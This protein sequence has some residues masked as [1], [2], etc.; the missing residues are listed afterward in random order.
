M[1]RKKPSYIM[2]SEDETYD[3]V[4]ITV[5]AVEAAIDR[6]CSNSTI[7][8]PD[9]EP[10]RGKENDL[11][12][13]MGRSNFGSRMGATS[14]LRLAQGLLI[15]E[16]D[17]KGRLQREVGSIVGSRKKGVSKEFLAKIW[18]IR[19][20][21]AQGAIDENT[22]LQRP[23]GGSTLSRRLPTSDRRTRYKRINSQFYTDTMFVDK[24][25]K[26]SGGHTMMQ[27]FVSDKGYISVYPMV[28]KGDFLDVLK[29]FCK[30]VGVPTSLVVDPSGEQTGKE[31][32]RF[33]IDVGTTLRVL[34]ESTQWANR[35]ELY[36]GMLKESIRKDLRRSHSPMSL[37]PFCARRR[38]LIHNLTPRDLYQSQGRSP[39]EITTGEQGDI[40]NLCQ[41]DWYDW[42]YYRERSNV[43][44]PY[45]V[46]K[47]GRVL[48]PTKDESNTMAQYV[49]N[50]LGKIVPRRSIRP[51]NAEEM[52]SETERRKRCE[53]DK[54]IERK[55]GNS[56]RIPERRIPD[57]EPRLDD[58]DFIEDND[59]T[60]DLVID[61][62][63]IDE[64][65]NLVYEKPLTDIFIGAEVNLPYGDELHRGE[66]L[67][68][69][70]CALGKE[71]G[72]R[73]ENLMSNGVQYDVKFPDGKIKKVSANVIAEH[74]Y[75]MCDE[76]GFS[77]S[78]LEEILDY[79]TDG[80]EVKKGKDWLTTPSGTRRRRESTTGW[81]IK[82]KWRDNNYLD[83]TQNLERV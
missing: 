13:S 31:V 68:R 17:I 71:V 41:F 27:L 14:R 75:S 80:T 50:D 26:S 62:D 66:I 48:C 32:K 51:L 11:A 82:V 36:I 58:R 67:Q 38:A 42:C 76:E 45:Q 35:A 4:E 70:T 43:Q 79:A 30:E 23:H 29:L 19:E 12:V 53:F 83:P 49:L 18:N 40:S 28:R 78:L 10:P 21:L 37:W 52:H 77:N 55:L 1:S 25:A 61:E 69:S 33:A 47:L 57:T 16:H 46:E 24:R 72:E 81:N 65:G 64:M 56:L 63:P 60:S 54:V 44:W 39:Y 73:N 7:M 5:A 3:D 9:H 22:Q 74:M 6:N 8:R 15:S 59:V 20:D 2:I 34:E